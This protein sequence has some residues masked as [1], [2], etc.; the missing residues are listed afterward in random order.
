MISFEQEI[1]AY[2]KENG[3]KFEDNSSSLKKMDFTI[4]DLFSKDWHI[5]AKEKRQ[6]I[7]II[8]WS[9][10]TKE[11]EPFTFIIDDLAA[12]KALAYAPRSGLVVRNNLTNKYYWF[13]ILDLFLM[14]KK[15]V[16]RKIEKNITAYKGKW[17]I[18]F[19]NAFESTS[20]SG[21][22]EQLKAEEHSILNKFTE[23]LECYGKYIGEDIL[24]QGE[25]RRPGHWDVDVT[26]TR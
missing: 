1:K 15:R 19:R 6:I 2:F 13:S 17:L 26:E 21:I 4:K 9:L 25:T 5:D 22:I 11:N 10:V 7:N 20:F 3:I 23:I 18:D 8:N 12:R 24:M 14:P 16:N